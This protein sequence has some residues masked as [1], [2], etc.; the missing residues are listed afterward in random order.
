MRASLSHLIIAFLS[1]ILVYGCSTEEETQSE[2][3]NQTSDEYFPVN[4][5]GNGTY[6]KNGSPYPPLSYSKE[7]KLDFLYPEGTNPIQMEIQ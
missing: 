6:Q 1:F 3:E 4:I 7:Q 5:I 2:S